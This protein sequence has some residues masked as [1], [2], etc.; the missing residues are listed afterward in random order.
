MLPGQTAQDEGAQDEVTQDEGGASKAAALGGVSW[1]K[2][3]A[4]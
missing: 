4:G 2:G 3:L 1:A